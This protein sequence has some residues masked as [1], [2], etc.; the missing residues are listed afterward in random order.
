M[1]LSGVISSL[2]L[3]FVFGIFMT[4]CGSGGGSVSAT[5]SS[6]GNMV[7]GTVKLSDGASGSARTYALE[8]DTSGEPYADA[9]V[10]LVD[11]EG[12]VVAETETDEDGNFNIDGVEEGDYTILVIDPETG[13]TV[14]EV[15]VSIVDGDDVLIEGVITGGEAEWT[16]E[17]TAN[18]A[19]LQNEAQNDKAKNIAMES[20]A[21]LDEVLAMREAG[22]GWGEIARELGVHPSVLGLGNEKGFEKSKKSKADEEAVSD[23]AKG[24]KGKGKGKDKDNKPD[25]GG[26]PDKDKPGKGKP[27]K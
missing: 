11:S 17:F 13:D 18:T 21:T 16:V 10:Q 19:D 24:G 6:G 1:R 14:T 12:N 15:E 23:S 7:S 9:I 27:K 4:A 5:G 8:G 26:K 2:A 22:M 20:D 25:K 3:V